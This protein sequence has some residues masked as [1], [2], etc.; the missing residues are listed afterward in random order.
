MVRRGIEGCTPDGFSRERIAVL[1]ESGDMYLAVHDGRPAGTFTL[2][3]SDRE[4]WGDVPDDAG[5]IH[6]LA[7][8]RSSQARDSGVRCS[9][10]PSTWCPARNESTSGSTA[11]RTTRP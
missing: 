1:M 8:R 6:G 2:Q 7:I 9:D 11:S 10:G 4:T 5:Y 3:W